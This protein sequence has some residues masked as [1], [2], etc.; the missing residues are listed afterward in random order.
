MTQTETTS[1][2]TAVFTLP[3]EFYIKCLLSHTLSLF[4]FSSRNMLHLEREKRAFYANCCCFNYIDLSNLKICTT[5]WV[6]FTVACFLLERGDIASQ[7]APHDLSKVG[8]RLVFTH[9]NYLH[10]GSGYEEVFMVKN[11]TRFVKQ[12]LPILSVPGWNQFQT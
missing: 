8:K 9:E 5:R 6:C 12:R 4:S 10:Y 2:W 1:K 11:M 3:Y 7:R